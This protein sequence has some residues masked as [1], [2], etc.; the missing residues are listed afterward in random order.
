MTDGAERL[1]EGYRCEHCGQWVQSYRRSITGMMAATLIEMVRHVE[2]TGA[3]AVHVQSTIIPRIIARTRT[4]GSSGD[5]AKLRY[6]DLI[7]PWEANPVAGLPERKSAGLWIV[8]REGVQF[9]ASL[10][11]VPKYAHVYNGD[12]RRLSGPLVSII[13]CLGKR[14]SYSDLR[15]DSRLLRDGAPD[16]AAPAQLGLL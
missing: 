15:G 13:E 14:F 16:P 7:Q 5:Y 6:W 1:A 8:T 4:G 12:V 9:A 2:R 3:R 10:V 11:A